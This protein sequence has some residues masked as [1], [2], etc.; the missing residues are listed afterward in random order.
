MGLV[1]VDETVCLGVAERVSGIKVKMEPEPQLLASLDRETALR[2]LLFFSAI[3]YDTR[4]LSGMVEGRYVRG[5]NYILSLMAKKARE[6]P[7]ILDPK[8]MA[9]LEIGDFISWF[10]PLG[11]ARVPRRPGERVALLRDTA[12]RLLAQ[13]GGSVLALLEACSGRIGGPGGLRERLAS[14]KAFDDPLAKKTM[15]FAILAKK[16]GLWEP[17]D[18]ENITVGVDYHLQRVALRS[19]MVKV[20]D[21]KLLRKLRARRFVS[22]RE[23]HEIREACLKAY[24]CVSEFSGL[25]QMEVDQIFWHIG[26]NCC[27]AEEPVCRGRRP[28]YKSKICSLV[29]ATDYNCQGYCPLDGVCE[30][31]LDPEKTKL[32][33]PKVIT[34]YY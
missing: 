21:E 19:G 24:T 7:A 22:S 13:Y 20:V 2:V 34:Y 1:E 29:G 25:S 3:N 33:E 14:F 16:E 26:R 30:A 28:C 31:S 27:R 6:D 18:P 4:G 17:S 15:V 10:G 12:E 8:R 5:S 9:E 23:H 11:E 32:K